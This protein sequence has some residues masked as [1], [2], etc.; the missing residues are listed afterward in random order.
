MGEFLL[1]YL[2]NLLRSNI[3][4]LAPTELEKVFLLV[5]LII[6]SLSYLE[7]CNPEIVRTVLQVP[8][9]GWMQIF[10]DVL[11]NSPSAI[12]QKYTAKTLTSMLA[13]LPQLCSKYLLSLVYPI[14]MLFN[15]SVV[16]YMTESMR[17]TTT[18][19]TMESTM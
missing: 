2:Y 5:Y 13:D 4:N 9:E 3:R 8:L 12:L 6:K 18:Q 10:I 19:A 15:R 7:D 1:P 17:N 16:G 14:W 11:N